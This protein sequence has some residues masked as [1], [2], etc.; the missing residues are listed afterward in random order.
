MNCL[1]AYV[2]G[3]QVLYFTELTHIKTYCVYTM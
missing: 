1:I 2:P 3:N